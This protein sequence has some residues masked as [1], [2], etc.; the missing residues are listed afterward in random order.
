MTYMKIALI[1]SQ[2]LYLKGLSLLLNQAIDDLTIVA[3]ASS[4][5]SLIHH[6]QGVI[7]D[8][9]VWDIPGHHVLTPGTRLL[10]ECFPLARI[11]VLVASKNAV[12]AG[13]L[14]TLG[15]DK[16]LPAD[17]E[18]ADLCNAI[19]NIHK[20]YAPPPS[21]NHVQEPDLA[22]GEVV[23]ESREIEFL[24]S[25]N[26]GL[27]MGQIAKKTKA[28]KAHLAVLLRSLKGKL[29]VKTRDQLIKK[30]LRQQ[31]IGSKKFQGKP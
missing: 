7:V 1:H 28:R 24:E 27:S 23:L 6:H 31:L 25:L 14:E 5:R 26:M 17:C 30:A 13:L 11:L 29:G 12:Y 9:I 16:V 3:T 18:L 20:S 10:K 21:S 19:L 15:A 4:L 22:E 8:V 2:P